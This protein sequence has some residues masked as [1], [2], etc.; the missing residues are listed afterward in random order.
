MD[1]N[2]GQAGLPKLFFFT[3]PYLSSF[4]YFSPSLRNV[5]SGMTL[6]VERCRGIASSPHKSVTFVSSCPHGGRSQPHFRRRYLEGRTA[7]YTGDDQH[8]AHHDQHELDQ[9]K[10]EFVN[11]LIEACGCS[12][13]DYS[14]CQGTEE[15]P[16]SCGND[17]CCGC[18]A[19]H[20]R[21][22]E[23][24]IIHLERACL[25]GERSV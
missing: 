11:A 25:P 5:P 17:Y 21:P 13:T 19:H 7:F 9:D 1:G 10:G 15:C 20:V 2:R 18:S 23:R 22:H 24:K 12:T 14:A 8:D 3:V 6:P 16:R 4:K